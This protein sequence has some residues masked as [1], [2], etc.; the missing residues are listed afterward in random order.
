MKKLEV[1]IL[2]EKIQY[3]NRQHSEIGHFLKINKQQ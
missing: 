1:H 2:E 3:N